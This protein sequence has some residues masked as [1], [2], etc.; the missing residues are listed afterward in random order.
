MYEIAICDDIPQICEEVRRLVAE[1]LGKREIDIRIHVYHSGQALLNAGI[2]F[3]ILFL[4]I[5]L[6][7][8]NGLQIAM[9][10]PYKK[11]TR[12]IFLTSHVEEMP[13]G[14]K[15]RAFRFLTKPIDTKHFEEALF[16]A[17]KDIERDKRFTIT[18]EDGEHIIRASEIYYL[19]SKQRSTDVRTKDKFARCKYSIEEMKEELDKMQFYCPHRS[20]MV[21]MDHIQSFEKDFV[22]MKNGEKV[23]VSRAKMNE[24]KDKFFEYMRSRAN[25]I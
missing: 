3:D 15:V 24:F 2:V 10:Y 4:D 22:R 23:K 16:S 21:N 9:E 20:Y 1:P 12:I 19:E 6:E 13:N 11:K 17:M 18:D 14:Y 7:K 25:G 8:E 5:E